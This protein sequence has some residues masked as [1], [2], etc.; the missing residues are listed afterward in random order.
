MVHCRIVHILSEQQ[1]LGSNSGGDH[2]QSQEN[3]VGLN[4]IQ[5]LSAE[6]QDEDCD[7]K[8]VRWAG[9]TDEHHGRHP[10]LLPCYKRN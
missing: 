7:A 6:R 3:V 10:H 4:A 1:T 5:N 2:R 8:T 9:S